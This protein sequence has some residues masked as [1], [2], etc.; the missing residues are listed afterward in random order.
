MNLSVK[1]S[2][3]PAWTPALRR[4][5]VESEPE[6]VKLVAADGTILDMNPAGL[7]M[8]EAD[9]AEQVIGESVYGLVTPAYHE[10]FRAFSEQVFQGESRTAE[11]EIIGLKGTKRWMESHACPLRNTEGK[12]MA[13]LAVTRDTTERKGAEEEL[14]KREAQYRRLIENIPEIVWTVDEQGKVL[15]ISE[16]ITKIFGYTPEDA[17]NSK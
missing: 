11:F 17:G 14:H 9:K 3:R 16:K 13:Q 5:I 1:S 12:I 2:T 6:C 4:S 15:L 10:T 7:A 8:I